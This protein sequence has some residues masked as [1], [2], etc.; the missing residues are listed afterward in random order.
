MPITEDGFVPYTAQQSLQQIQAVFTTVF[1]SS[2]NFAP[3]GVNGQFTQELANINQNQQDQLLQIYAQNFDPRY[4]SGIFLDTICALNGILRLPATPSVVVCQ[5]T[6]IVGTVIDAGSQVLNTNGDLFLLD[7]QVTIPSGGVIN[8]TFSSFED[9]PIECGANTLT[10]IVQQVNGWSTVNNTD[11]G[12]IGTNT[13]TDFDLRNRYN[14]LLGLES[15][16]GIASVASA[17]YDSP[18]IPNSNVQQNTTDSPLSILGVTISPHAIYISLVPGAATQNDIAALIVSKAPPGCGQDGNTTYTYTDP[19][20]SWQTYDVTYQVAVPFYVQVNVMLQGLSGDYPGDINVQIQN[21]I[22]N[23]FY[24][25]DTAIGLS[26]VR[27]G[28]TIFANRFYASL[29]GLGIFT[30]ESITIQEYPSGMEVSFLATTLD[31]VPMISDVD[32]G[33]IP[34]GTPPTIYVIVGFSG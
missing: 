28:A 19:R 6:G 12:V 22:Y 20:Y 10:R 14:Y 16:G 33:P 1:G 9:E 7:T 26:R 11:A 3:P 32:V 25:Y 17:F 15:S 24:G 8:G 30:T 29:I 13:E 31:V 18:I 21:A 4:A 5:L 23:N 27:I 34:P 2:C